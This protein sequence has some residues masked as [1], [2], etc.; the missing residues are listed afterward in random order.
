MKCLN[1]G[2]ENP[3]DS[4]QCNC[5][6]DFT[7]RTVKESYSDPTPKT[8]VSPANP[9]HSYEKRPRAFVVLAVSLGLLSLPGAFLSESPIT[10]LHHAY[11]IVLPTPFVAITGFIFGVLQLTRRRS[12]RGLAFLAILC[13]IIGFAMTFMPALW[14]L[15]VL[16]VGG[17]RP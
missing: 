3:P 1:C 10:F 4:L 12:A 2:L 8:M 15:G 11:W 9:T 14:M 17:F 7:T 6:Y 5:G 16:L 13:S